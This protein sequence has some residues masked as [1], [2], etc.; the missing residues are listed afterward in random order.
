MLP[1]KFHLFFGR[2]FFRQN[3]PFLDPEPDQKLHAK[4][5]SLYREKGSYVIQGAL[6][7][8]LSSSAMSI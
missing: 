2:P 1:G 4:G 5:R 7:S 8:G 3:I 6:A